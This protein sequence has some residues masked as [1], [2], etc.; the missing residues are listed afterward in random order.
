MNSILALP[1]LLLAGSLAGLAPAPEQEP[2]PR[3][4]LVEIPAGATYLGATHERIEELAAEF[5]TSAPYLASELGRHKRQVN[6]FWI[7]PT[8]VTNE[9]YLGFVQDTGAIPPP[10]WAVI[11]KE[12]RQELIREG[13]ELDR[14]FRF[15]DAAQAAWWLEHWSDEGREWKMPGSEALNPVVFV[16]YGDAV[17]FC[18][19]AGLRMP[20]EVEWTRAA[21]SDS[22]RE[23]PWGDEFDRKRA[24]FNGT[25]PRS[26]ASKLV[27]VGSLE[28]AS[29]FG[30]VDMVGLVW[31]FTES[32]YD[33]HDDPTAKERVEI[34][35]ASGKQKEKIYPEFDLSKHVIKGG[36]Y[37]ADRETIRIDA[38]VGFDPGAKAPVLGFRVAASENRLGDFANMQGRAGLRVSLRESLAYP[39]AV[40]VSTRNYPDMKVVRGS[41]S[42]PEAPLR[43]PVLP[44]SYQVFGKCEA[45]VITPRLDAFDREPFNS[46]NVAKIDKGAKAGDLPTIGALTTSVSFTSVVRGTKDDALPAGVYTLVYFPPMKNKEIKELGGY[47]P[48][49]AEEERPTEAETTPSVDISG[50][51]IEP[52]TAHILVVDTARKARMALPLLNVN[53]KL[54]FQSDR[55]QESSVRIDPELDRMLFDIELNGKSGKSYLFGIGLRPVDAEGNSLVKE[56]AW[57]AGTFTVVERKKD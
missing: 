44:D 26:Y 41:R 50:I 36:C 11:S 35:D 25:E 34:M 42:A 15:D 3:P 28:N 31:E 30:M 57:D 17:R 32:R 51:G 21:R 10:S 43:S 1:V 5:R 54:K 46:G 38:R 37:L 9:M 22:Q 56:S 19:W 49:M 55:K 16:S 29:P 18:A 27:P 53:N 39:N 24:T 12:L 6:R 14:G 20:S 2:G 48:K 4:G 40:G 13:K 52:A 7:A 8:K 23:Y 33:Y 45:F 47:T